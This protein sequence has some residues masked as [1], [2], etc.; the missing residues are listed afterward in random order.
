M[1]SRP[2]TIAGIF[3]LLITT[4]VALLLNQALILVLPWL[5]PAAFR[6]P[7]SGFLILV[8][9]AL[10]GIWAGVGLGRWLYRGLVASQRTDDFADQDLDLDD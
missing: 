2:A 6:L 7:G 9:P 1:T 4:G 8:V 10:I 3:G 5:F